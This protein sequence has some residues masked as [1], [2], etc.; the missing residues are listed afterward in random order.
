MSTADEKLPEKCCMRHEIKKGVHWIAAWNHCF[1]FI[2][3]AMVING[4]VFI[5]TR[6]P[7]ELTNPDGFDDQEIYEEKEQMWH[8]GNVGH[9]WLTSPEEVEMIGEIGQDWIDTQDL[10]V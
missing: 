3:F 4:L 10:A 7:M 1:T 6:R 5:L 2:N 8:A 9:P